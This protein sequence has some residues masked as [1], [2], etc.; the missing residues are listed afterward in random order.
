M[1]GWGGG[2][3]GDKL[4]LAADKGCCGEFV[5][6][7]R[8]CTVTKERVSRETVCQRKLYQYH[9]SSSRRINLVW[10]RQATNLTAAN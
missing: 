6:G 10:L 7:E 3:D 4:F 8:E 1:G 2:E 9:T 5:S